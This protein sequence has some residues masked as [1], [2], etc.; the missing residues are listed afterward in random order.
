MAESR[1]W[2]GW[3]FLPNDEKLWGNGNLPRSPHSET[4]GEQPYSIIGNPTICK[5]AMHAYRRAITAVRYAPDSRGLIVCRVRLGVEIIE[6]DDRAY[7]PE[8]TVLWMA[9]A[10]RALHEFALW[11]A[12]RSLRAAHV[13][14][15]R[16][17]DALDA[18]RRWLNGTATDDELAAARAAADDA[19][20]D[21]AWTAVW[22]AMATARGA[23][24]AA[25]GAAA[26][27]VVMNAAAAASAAVIAAA[28][29]DLGDAAWTAAGAIAMDA[30]RDAADIAADSAEDVMDAELDR[31]LAALAPAKSGTL[32]ERREV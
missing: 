21:A 26:G 6:N 17:W 23:A 18:K 29:D 4:R 30:A 22:A 27:N 20:A 12:E 2:K 7:A 8:H 11:C 13:T 10:T 14:D 19:T 15:E 24:E 32:A 28:R 25:A 5:E 31:R 9:D 3:Y 16:C 1:A